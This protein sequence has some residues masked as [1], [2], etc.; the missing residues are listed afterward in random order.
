MAQQNT[1]NRGLTASKP[2]INA[3]LSN[4]DSIDDNDDQWRYSPDRDLASLYGFHD[5]L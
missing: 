3:G 5:S 2:S 4:G 1:E